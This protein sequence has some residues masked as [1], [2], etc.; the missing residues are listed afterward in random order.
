MGDRAAEYEEA[1]GRLP[2]AK[3]DTDTAFAKW[4]RRGYAYKRRKFYERALTDT[5]Q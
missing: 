1:N 5:L 3:P 2:Y 4:W